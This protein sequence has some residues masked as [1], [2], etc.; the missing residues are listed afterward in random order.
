MADV[1]LSADAYPAVKTG[2][3]VVERGETYM[4]LP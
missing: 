4:Q 1:R 2:I 3:K